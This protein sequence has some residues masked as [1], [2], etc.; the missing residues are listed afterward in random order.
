MQRRLSLAVIVLILPALSCGGAE[1]AIEAEAPERIRSV[2]PASDQVQPEIAQS[3]EMTL[4][5][6]DTLNVVR[7][8][9]PFLAQ[10]SLDKKLTQLSLNPADIF[11]SLVNAVS[12][13]K[14]SFSQGMLA[15]ELNQCQLLSTGQTV[16][17]TIGFTID[18]LLP[19]TWTLHLIDF[20][21]ANRVF[22]GS[23]TM[24]GQGFGKLPVISAKIGLPLG[25]STITLEIYQ[26][27][28]SFAGL[29]LILNGKGHLQTSFLGGDFD[30][31]DLTWQFGDCLPTSGELQFHQI[32]TTVSFL[33][34][35]P[36]TG[37]VRIQLPLLPPFEQAFLPACPF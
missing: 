31:V 35:T 5:V 2:A 4:R 1:P 19:F 22:N 12:C 20:E 33:P 37:A 21:V 30:M 27:Q 10:E 3:T 7:V 28:I 15:F 18:Q 16:S 34:T 26:A 36:S 29:A 23:L 13:I 25:G 6:V 11:T 17:G 24:T 9:A 14:P 8:L 32:F